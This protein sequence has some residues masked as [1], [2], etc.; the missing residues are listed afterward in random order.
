MKSSSIKKQNKPNKIALSLPLVGIAFVII[1]FFALVSTVPQPVHLVTN[2]QSN[3]SDAVFSIE[4]MS[5]KN[6]SYQEFETHM[7]SIQINPPPSIIIELNFT[8][9]MIINHPTVYLVSGLNGCSFW[10][11]LTQSNY[12]QLMNQEYPG[13]PDNSN[14]PLNPGNYSFQFNFYLMPQNNG[15][16]PHFPSEFQMFIYLTSGNFTSSTYTIQLS[17]QGSKATLVPNNNFTMK[18]YE[19]TRTIL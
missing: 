17:N 10:A 15:I 8:I 14:V 12:W 2:S 4:S 19:Q 7:I 11:K 9:I 13:C 6:I 3:F 18:Y 5:S 1:V 16:T